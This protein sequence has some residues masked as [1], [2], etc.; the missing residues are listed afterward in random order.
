MAKKF[1]DYIAEMVVS[2]SFPTLLTVILTSLLTAMSGILVGI[3]F[4]VLFGILGASPLSIM[5]REEAKKKRWI[6]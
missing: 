5:I 2:E 6:K 4:G 3:V 1:E